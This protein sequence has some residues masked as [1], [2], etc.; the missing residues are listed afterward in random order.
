MAEKCLLISFY[1]SASDSPTI[2]RRGS[3]LN[4]STV[5]ILAWI[6]S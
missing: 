6:L 5:Y 4:F 2:N 1:S 3:G